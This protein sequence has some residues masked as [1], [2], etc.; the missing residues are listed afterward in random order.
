MLFRSVGSKA[1]AALVVSAPTF[2]NADLSGQPLPP[3][4]VF[5][6]SR[7]LPA[8]IS[9]AEAVRLFLAEFGILPSQTLLYKD[10]SGSLLTI[11]SGFFIQDSTGAS[12]LNSE[13]RPYM[14]MYA[15]TIK[16]PDEIIEAWE[17]FRDSDGRYILKRRYLAVWQ[18]LGQDKATVA[19]FTLTSDTW[20]AATALAVRKSQIITTRN[21]QLIYRRKP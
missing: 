16:N 9:D 19:S 10:A 13:R 7:L 5:E 18:V 17:T 21:G 3:P 6:P 14:L 4:R 1:N 15:D 8:D 12:K 20:E 11:G 2:V